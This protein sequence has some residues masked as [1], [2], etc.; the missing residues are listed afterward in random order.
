MKNL[1]NYSKLLLST[2]I[3]SSLFVAC[4]E[5]ISETTCD[6][7]YIANTGNLKMLVKL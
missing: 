5:E 3:A 2:L 7:P 4:S 1:K 6:T